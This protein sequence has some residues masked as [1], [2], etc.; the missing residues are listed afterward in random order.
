[1]MNALNGKLVF[2]PVIQSLT[3]D[4]DDW[5]LFTTSMNCDAV[6]E[7]LNNTF[8]ACVNNGLDKHQTRGKMH[9]IMN[10]NSKYGAADSEPEHMLCKLLD[11]VFG[12]GTGR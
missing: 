1:M 9:H 5:G 12:I 4:G 6:V 2:K 3:L 8:A 10:L 7:K 11:T